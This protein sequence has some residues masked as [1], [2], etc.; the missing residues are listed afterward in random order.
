MEKDTVGGLMPN[1]LIVDDISANLVILSDMVKEAGCVPRPVINVG[2]AWQ[3][4]KKK[5][6]QLILL[7]ITM[8]EING[9][10]FCESL[11]HDMRTRDIPI[12]FI[13]ALDS[14]QNKIRGFKLGAVDFIVKPFEKEEVTQRINT[15]LK[16]H[17][18]Q[19]ELERYNQQL[20][21]MVSEQTQQIRQEEKEILQAMVEL[22]AARE[23]QGTEHL[24]NVG[25]NSRLLTIGL[26]LSVKY[27]QQITTSFVDDMEAAS[28]LHDVGKIALPDQVLLKP[29]HLDAK[30]RLVMETHS[31]LGACQLKKVFQKNVGSNFLKMALE[32]AQSHH[33]NWD[34][35]GYPE[36]LQGDEI[37]LSARIVKVVDVFDALTHERCYK[38]A[39]DRE[40]SLRIMERGSGTHFD[41]GIMEVFFKIQ[42]QL[43]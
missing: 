37:P 42:K 25:H 12:I 34:G 23:K 18:M 11:K 22:L 21:K 1:I 38:P 5:I 31:V 9:Y 4:I 15:H 32:I 33:E 27:E 7:D 29:G 14:V 28:K 10:E 20:H 36:G 24:D 13:S 8:P 16:M 43:I 3:A 35:T 40:E 19:R 30:E 26:Q 6:P 41:P 17:Q 2:Q 39:Y